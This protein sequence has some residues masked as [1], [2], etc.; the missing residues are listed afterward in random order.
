MHHRLQHLE[1]QTQTLTNQ[2]TQTE[3]QTNKDTHT[4]I[5]PALY[6]LF[7][8]C[9]ILFVI[10]QSTVLY[11]RGGISS[12]PIFIEDS[13]LIVVLLTNIFYLLAK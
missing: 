8:C 7:V 3:T 1:K 2:N 12:T 5:Y 13:L 4:H 9:K 6:K 10:I 11:P